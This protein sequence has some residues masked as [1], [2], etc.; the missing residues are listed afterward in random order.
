MKAKLRKLPPVCLLIS[1]AGMLTGRLRLSL[2]HRGEAMRMEDGSVFRIFRN[3]KMIRQS[4]T[5][6]SQSFQQSCV[7]VVR[8]KFS[9]LS[10]SANKIASVLPMMIIAGSPGFQQKIYAVNPDNGYWQGMYQWESLAH[11]EEYKK[12]FIYRMMNKRAI[13]ESIQTLQWEDQTLDHFIQLHTDI[14]FD[15]HKSQK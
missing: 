14:Q 4:T 9:R 2:R 6:H 1:L 10:H 8:F 3:F 5:Q 15:T 12:S 11:L 7:F 13:P